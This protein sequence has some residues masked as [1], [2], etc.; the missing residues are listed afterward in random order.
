MRA[1]ASGLGLPAAPEPAPDLRYV[2]ELKIDGLAISLRYDRGRFAQ[3]ATRGDGTTGE[4]VTANL[5]TIAVIPARLAEAASLEARGEVFMPKAEFKRINEEREEAGLPLYAN[6][7]N[8]GAGSLRQID[9]AVTAGRKLSAW[10]YQLVEDGDDGGDPD[11]GSGTPGGARLPGQPGRRVRAR[12]RGRH[13]LHR[14]LARGPPRAPVRDRRRRG[15]GRPV[16]PAGPTRDGQPG[17]ALGDRLQVPA[18]AGR[19]VR[20]GHRPVRRP[21]R[22]AHPG[23]PHD[24]G[25]GRRLDRRPGDPPQ[26]RRGPAQGHP[27]RRLGHPPEGRRRHPGG[28]PPD[29]RA[30]DR[31]GARV[32]DAATV[33]GLRH[34]GRPGRGRGPGLLPEH[35]LPGP[36]GPGVRPLRRSRRDGH[37]GCRLGGPRRSC[38]SA[39]WSIPGATSSG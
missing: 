12:H 5:R 32:R 6:P 11:G 34:A 28:R 31:L 4:D 36:P 16:R 20:R 23:R 19:G 33:P 17:A 26:P 39:G 38:S 35:G 37:R 25:Q 3:G 21:D 7:R 14:T 2:A 9:P 8:S 18:G 30:A 15:Q 1:C 27:D 10:F 29:R 22:D 13:R 24:P